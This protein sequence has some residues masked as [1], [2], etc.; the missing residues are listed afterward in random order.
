[1]T[2][3]Y[4][5]PLGGFAGGKETG[6]TT[7][8]KFL[9]RRFGYRIFSFADPIRKLMR[10]LGVTKQYYTDDKDAIIPHLGKSA[11]FCMQTLGTNWARK[12]ISETIW[13]D[14]M[15]RRLK[16]AKLHKYLIT[17]D[18]VRFDNEAELVKEFGGFLIRVERGD[19]PSDSHVS[20]AGISDDLVDLAIE[21]HGT[22]TELGLIMEELISDRSLLS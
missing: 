1:M 2:S 17:I 4:R 8:S 14:M 7:A 13:L 5:M 15:A 18:D 9:K 21:N 20:E 10:A 6:K 3:A 12:Q 19:T 16:D 11:R 22:V